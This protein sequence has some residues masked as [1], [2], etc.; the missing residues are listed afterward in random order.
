MKKP[1]WVTVVGV[2]GIIFSCLGILG[3]GQEMLMPKMF[4]MQQEMLSNFETIVEQEMERERAKQNYQDDEYQSSP[5]M[6]MGMFESFS[7]MLDFPEWYGTWSIISGI[8]KLLVCAFF[9]LASIRLLQLNPSSINLFYAAALASIALGLVKAAVA[10]HAGSFL[11]MAMIFGSVFGIIIDII[12]II[13]VATGNKAAFY[14]QG[15]PPLPQR[16]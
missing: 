4:K 8:L 15:P 12:L 1:T 2:L 3:A 6:P 9:L 5:E 14:Q 7:K 16:M 10:M 13:V 11:A